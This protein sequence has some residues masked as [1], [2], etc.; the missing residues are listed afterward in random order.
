MVYVEFNRP[1]RLFRSK[2]TLALRIAKRENGIIYE[3]KVITIADEELTSP[4]IDTLL[5]SSIIKRKELMELKK[6][7]DKA[8]CFSIARPNNDKACKIAHAPSG[9]GLYSNLIFDKSL[10]P[11]EREK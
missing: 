3:N 8:G 1:N 7:L 9:I 5:R 11:E 4:R 2:E 6:Y 10:Q